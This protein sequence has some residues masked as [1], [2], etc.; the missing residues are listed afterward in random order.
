MDA[1]H[2]LGI[3]TS[4]IIAPSIIRFAELKTLHPPKKNA[5]IPQGC[6]QTKEWRARVSR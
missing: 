5:D 4:I 2:T 1:L 3:H 6:L